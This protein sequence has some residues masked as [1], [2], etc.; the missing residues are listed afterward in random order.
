[1]LDG[2]FRPQIET[3]VRPIGRSVN[4]S[5]ISADV[6]TIVGIAMS[7]ACAVAIA[8][9]ALRLGLLLMILTG[10]PDLLDGAV[11]KASGTVSN[12]GAFFDS[13]SDRLTD[14]LL[15]GAVAWHLTT[16]SDGPLPML[17][18]GVMITA[19]L[20][21]YI[22]AKADALGYDAHVG[23]IERAERFVLLGL[24]LLFD[25]LLIVVLVIT[26]VLNIVTIAQRF[27]AVWSQASKPPLDPQR[28]QRRRSRTVGPD[29]SDRWRQRRLEARERARSRRAL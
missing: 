28:R 7:V 24:G 29:A 26:L 17:P 18:V 1:M 12:R 13:V 19:F 6:I 11:A 22:R 23:L 25:R 27:A 5:G 10:V 3:W 2:R 20:V 14:G 9:G 4:R 8:L 15:F 16:T 21:S